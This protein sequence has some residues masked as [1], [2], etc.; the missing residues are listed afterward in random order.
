MVDCGDD[1]GERLKVIPRI[2]H[3]G[4]IHIYMTISMVVPFLM[5]EGHTDLK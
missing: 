4:K 3:W 5:R 2:L 1:E